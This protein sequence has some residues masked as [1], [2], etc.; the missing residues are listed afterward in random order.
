[1]RPQH[2]TADGIGFS[3]DGLRRRTTIVWSDV[4]IRTRPCQTPSPRPTGHVGLAPPSL[5]R[6]CHATNT[7]HPPATLWGRRRH[8]PQPRPKAPLPGTETRRLG[9][10]TSGKV[11]GLG[12]EAREASDRVKRLADE[13]RQ[14]VSATRE[15]LRGTLDS[16][17]A[18]RKD[19]LQLSPDALQTE[20]KTQSP[21]E[22][23]GNTAGPPPQPAPVTVRRHNL[24]AVRTSDRTGPRAA[25]RG[26]P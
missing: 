20:P 11:R 18:A 16:A 1:M 6:G 13:D 5:R 7:T 2:V 14:G 4:V 22:R 23:C 25:L 21:G 26:D 10:Q 8:G 3:G 17:D 9:R 24:V 12:P 19:L 15:A